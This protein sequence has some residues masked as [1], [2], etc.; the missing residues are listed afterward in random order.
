MTRP[1]GYYVH[2][3][4]AG[5]SSRARAIAAA[6]QRPVTLI[7]TGLAS[8]GGFDTIDLPDDRLPGGSA[9]DGQ[10][11]ADTRPDALHYAPTDHCG[12]RGRVAAIAEWIR[13][14]RPA[15]IVVDVSV[16]VAMLARLC[17]VPTLYVRLNG[18]RSDPAH[19]DAFRGAA[20]LLAPFDRRLDH[21]GVPDWV[22]AKTHYFSGLGQ[23][24]PVTPPDRKGL[25]FV[26][27]RGGGV[28]DGS[29]FVA[30][31]RANPDLEI[32]VAG[33]LTDRPACP[34]NLRLLGWTDQVADVIASARCI[35]GAAGDGL[36]GQVFAAA[37]PFI[38]IPE[39]RPYGEQDA[40]ASALRS[41]DAALVLNAW[42]PPERWSAL[43]E[44]AVV[45]AAR[46]P[47][48]LHDPRGAAKAAAWIET[49]ADRCAA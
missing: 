5:H 3:H 31:A 18:D 15:M 23:D 26:L 21:P 44:E 41:L 28:V 32:S 7:G 34:P 49:L 11:A 2:H 40:K 9:F 4:G 46:R 36:V 16:E 47:A 25:L 12:I 19:L 17:S 33:D 45:Q 8:I 42:P 43:V 20:A 14:A 48:D 35:V 39:P 22:V 1:I 29:R 37:S 27:G 30:I 13:D 6:M 24:A 38:C 10:D